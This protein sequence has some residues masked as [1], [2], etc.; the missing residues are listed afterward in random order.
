MQKI[1]FRKRKEVVMDYK[2]WAQEYYRGAEDILGVVRKYEK[3]RKDGGWD[4]EENLNSVI[5]SYRYIY[6]DLFNTAKML[7]QRAQGAGNAA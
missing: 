1:I 4:N 6:Y 7:D 2:V 5:M 3:I